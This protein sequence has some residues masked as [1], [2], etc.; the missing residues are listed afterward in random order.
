M[1]R[2]TI[3]L[4]PRARRIRARACGATL[5]LWIAASVWMTAAVSAV[6]VAMPTAPTVLTP[7]IALA[8]L[9][10]DTAV[11]AGWQEAVVSVRDA[12]ALL[13]FLIEVAG[14]QLRY[15]A[16]MPAATLDFY[17]GSAGAWPTAPR[18][19]EWLVTD[20]AGQPGFVR[21]L[22]F[23][24]PEASRIRSGA[25][26]W[27][28]GGLL[29]LMTRSNATAAVYR[30]AQALGWTSFND[31]VL[32]DM[33]DTGVQLTNVVMQGPEGVVV[34]VY[35]RLQPRMPDAVDLNRLR[36]PFNAM[37][38]VRDLAVA[39]HFYGE[40]LG[41]EVVNEGRFENPVRAPNNF[42]VPAN[43]VVAQ[44]M[45]FAIYG[46]RRTGPTQVELVQF[47]G[48]EGRDLADR[49]VAP[50]LGLLALRFPV[51][52]LA[53]IEQRLRTAGWPISAGPAMLSIAPYG[54]VRILAVRA[55]DGARLEFFERISS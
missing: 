39:R 52:H 17:A 48:V 31:P 9:D 25:M 34:S 12:P 16:L 13:R 26:P 38:S 21:L 40:V 50:N 19:R 33:R 49:A 54:R 23:D 20:A 4:L 28:T 1:G 11:D 29:S 44:P 53:A 6:P 2:A 43:L 55:P 51:R 35:E 42:G 14:W 36:R 5:S 32:L 27:D 7:R 8:G 24:Q 46:P 47:A 37:Q 22:S 10:L 3:Q 15:Q 41:F 18:R 45:P 30:A